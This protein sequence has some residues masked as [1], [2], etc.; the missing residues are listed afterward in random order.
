MPQISMIP[1]PLLNARR[2]ADW[3]AS[4]KPAHTDPSCIVRNM[5][6]A[7]CAM[8]LLEQEGVDQSRQYACRD[9]IRG[10]RS[11]RMLHAFNAK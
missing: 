4:H 9:F 5:A 3:C 10:A 2:T 7:E 11:V 1:A 6:S 8:R